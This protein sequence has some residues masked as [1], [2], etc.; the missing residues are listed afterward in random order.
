MDAEVG[1]ALIEDQVEH[2]LKGVV[3]DQSLMGIGMK[4]EFEENFL[5]EKNLNVVM[6]GIVGSEILKSDS[7]RLAGVVEQGV[8]VDD[9]VVGSGCL[10]MGG[11]VKDW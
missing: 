1:H 5:S 2:G 11:E 8:L 10:M 7:E 4:T 6:N 3:S 9:C